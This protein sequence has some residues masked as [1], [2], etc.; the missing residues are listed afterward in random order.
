[1]GA[2]WSARRDE[3]VERLGAAKF[4]ALI[5]DYDGTMVATDKRGDPPNQPVID[6]LRKL[7]D[8]GVAIALATGRG[9][10]VGEELRGCF[11]PEHCSRMLVGYYNGGHIVPLSVDIRKIHLEP[12]AAIS[13]AY[14]IIQGEVGMFQNGWLPKESPFQITIGINRLAFPA[15]GVRRLREI[16]STSPSLRM[17]RSG[18]S[19]DICPVWAAKPRVLEAIRPSMAEDSLQ[20]LA[21]GDSGEIAENAVG[22]FACPIEADFLHGRPLVQKP[23]FCIIA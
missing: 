23:N 9:G 13:H 20:M 4:G 22:L 21:I 19:I 16:V 6:R 5:L 10:S 1:M 18:H 11:S 12:D 14:R 17:V 2:A 15:D 7:L 8:G 3:F